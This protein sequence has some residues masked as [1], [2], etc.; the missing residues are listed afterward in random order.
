MIPLWY[1]LSSLTGFLILNI[2]FGNISKINNVNYIKSRYNVGDE[3]FLQL[4]ASETAKQSN[5]EETKKGAK[6]KVS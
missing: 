1:I 2:G 3:R 4:E 6:L 5:K